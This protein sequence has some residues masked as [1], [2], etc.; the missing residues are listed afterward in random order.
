MKNPTVITVLN[1][2]QISIE[3][4][5]GKNPTQNIKLYQLQQ[6]V[7]YNNNIIEV[8]EKVCHIPPLNFEMFFGVFFG[9]PQFLKRKPLSLLN[10]PLHGQNRVQLVLPITST[11]RYMETQHNNKRLGGLESI[12]LTH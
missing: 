3:S 8:N 2:V 6:G 7:T 5:R 10:L 1:S 12:T 11:S 4:R 9:L